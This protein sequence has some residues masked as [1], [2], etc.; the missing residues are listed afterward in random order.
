MPDK[1]NIRN[2]KISRWIVQH[3]YL[4]FHLLV[5]GI[6][7][8]YVVSHW[9]VCISM[10][11]F[12]RFDG[13]NIL[14]LVWIILIFLTIYKVKVKDVEICARNM[15]EKYLDA[16]MRNSIEEREQRLKSIEMHNAQE[17][18]SNKIPKK[19]EDTNGSEN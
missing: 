15:E 13:N 3:P 12:S 4:A 18:M 1:E 16:D 19:G 9:N 7:T 11:F 8:F 10:Q 6:L 17:Q 14:F 5:L 2:K